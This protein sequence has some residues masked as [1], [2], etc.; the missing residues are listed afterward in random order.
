MVISGVG[1][2][3]T[4]CPHLLRVKFKSSSRSFEF[5]DA[6]A[7]ASLSLT[8][9]DCGGFASGIQF[10]DDQKLHG[11]TEAASYYSVCTSII[12]QD[13]KISLPRRNPRRLTCTVPR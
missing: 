9:V 8:V 12:P 11:G 7:H 5:D 3:L 13:G 10:I 1:E 4:Y 6:A 2:V